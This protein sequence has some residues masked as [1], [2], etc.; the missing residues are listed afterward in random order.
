[1]PFG[2]PFSL[3]KF[4]SGPDEA[5]RIP[6]AHFCSLLASLF[7]A[8]FFRKLS[9]LSATFRDTRPKLMTN[10]M[11]AASLLLGRFGRR[12]FY[13]PPFFLF[14][15]YQLSPPPPNEFDGLRWGA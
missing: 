10:P 5:L 14:Y 6:W 11:W 9:R 12:T 8:A 7:S 3:V 2:I 15:R 4:L 1:L 13:F